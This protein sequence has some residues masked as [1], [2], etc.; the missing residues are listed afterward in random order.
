MTRLRELSSTDHGPHDVAVLSLFANAEQRLG[1]NDKPFLLDDESAWL[2]ESG[3]V[4]VFSVPGQGATHPGS[5]THLF[6]VS[7]R[8]ALF[9]LATSDGSRERALLAVGTNGAILRRLPRAAL[10]ERAWSA[11]HL[12]TMHALV[13][14]WVETVC[15]GIT[16]GVVPKRCEELDTGTEVTVSQPTSV[17]PRR[18]VAWIRHRE[19]HSL[20]FGN[21][22]LPVNGSGYV[23]LSRLTW[24]KVTEPSRLLVLD[25][26]TLPDARELWD[27]L[28]RLHALVL[29]YAAVLETETATALADRLRRK[30][31]GKAAS[32]RNACALLVA[33]M[34]PNGSVAAGAPQPPTNA[35]AN[36]HDAIFAACEIVARHLDVPLRPYHKL[37][38]GSLPPDPLAAIARASRLRTRTVLLRDDWWHHD[39]GHLLGVLADGQRPVALIRGAR[40]YVVHDPASGTATAVDGAVAGRLHPSAQTFYRRF[41]DSALGIADVVR[42]GLRGCRD[43]LVVVAVMG[44]VAA[45]LALVPPITTGTIFNSIIPGAQRSQLIQLSAILIACAASTA[46]FNLVRAFALLRV[47]GRMSASIQSAVWDRLLSLP[48][49]FFRPYA[50]GDLAVRAMGIDAMRQII[51]GTTISAI[52]GG[53]FSLSNFALMFYYSS[54][55][56]LRASLLIGLAVSAAAAGS[57]LQLKNQRGIAAVQS[58][59]S[60]MVLQLLSSVTKLRVANA[61]VAAFTLWARRFAQQRRLE[62][63]AR[64]IGN[65]VLAFNAAFPM[66]AYAVLFW[67]ALPL[68]HGAHASI[69][70]GDFLA[71]LT[72]YGAC[73][74]ALLG[75]CMA[76]LNTLSV[77]PLY[78]QARPILATRPEVDVGKT[79][80]GALIGDVEMQ[81][82]T[83]RY[84]PEGAPVLRGLSLHVR[85]GEFVAIVGPSGSGKST[86]FRLLLGFEAPESGAI[87]YDGQE[88]A[89]LDIPAVR[90]QIGVVLQ[91][92]RLLSGDL[93][94][95]IVG[96]SP[97]TVEDAW[98]AAEMA[99]FADDIRAMPMGMHTVVSEGGG[100]LSGGQRQRLMIAR[101]LVH[102][103]RLL[104]FDEATSALDNRTQHTVSNSLQQLRATRVV[105][106]HRLSTIMNADRIYVIERG[107]IVQSGRYEDLLLETG[108][109]AALAKRQIA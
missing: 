91:S 98:A 17:R 1:G 50:A 92:G 99:G 87:Y 84:S 63:K 80:P 6:R 102:R 56:G 108:L 85:S 44:I 93:F 101:A 38:D 88:L 30:E 11:L 35:S 46:M 68:V 20:L 105:V 51:S 61:E 57:W 71:F 25:T 75:T 69:R 49:P 90:R 39:N 18:S 15:A 19:G 82:V 16:R 72:A 5:R 4:D 52:I 32:L 64:T 103:P 26:L 21:D 86:I 94:T 96:S 100:T 95:N 34:T 3:D 29:R 104:F 77:I 59:A 8:R 41:P 60:G 37:E 54:T 2:V 22:A 55:L 62:Y 66:V 14:E 23:P 12:E 9:G 67:T 10:R 42:T 36:Q 7:A 106:A 58:K 48:M 28:D 81:G 31:A 33:A 76:L 24:L 13:D 79:D 53:V 83:F 70:T 45:L 78:E 109:F 47:E 74:G 43:D 89:G 73:Q 65:G 97:L 107:Q 27:G 40:G